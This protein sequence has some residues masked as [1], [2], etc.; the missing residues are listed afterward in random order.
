MPVEVTSHVRTDDDGIAWIDETR[1]KV[2]EV[3]L[4]HIAYGWSAEEI[5]RQHPNLS[6]AQCHSAL[7]YYY[8]NQAQFDK[9]IAESYARADK[10]ARQD[11]RSPVRLKLRAL[12]ILP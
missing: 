7:A 12:G 9:A 1:I 8:D 2:I 5:H 6:L 3:A 4:D 11:D 10:M